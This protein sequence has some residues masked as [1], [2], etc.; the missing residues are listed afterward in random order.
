MKKSNL[1]QTV[2]AVLSITLACSFAIARS[3]A[4]GAVQIDITMTTDQRSQL[5]QPVKVELHNT[6]FRV[7]ENQKSTL[8]TYVTTSSRGQSSIGFIRKNLKIRSIHKDENGKAR[9][10]RVA[11]IEA[12]KV[13][14]SAGSVDPLLTKN[15][16]VYRL[17]EAAGIQTMKTSYAELSIN[18]VSQGLH[19]VSESPDDHIMKSLNAD[20]AFRI[21]YA[22]S[23]EL[24]EAKKS[25]TEADIAQYTAA[26]KSI[27]ADVKN[28]KGAAL[29]ASLQSK[30]NLDRY[31]RL[32]AMNFLVKSGDYMGELYFHGTKNEK[33][34]ICFDVF[35]WDF[36]DSFGTAMHLSSIP[37]YSNNGRSKR[38][39]RQ[40]LYSFE[41][42]LD[43]A[44]SEDPYLMN[45]YFT[46]FGKVVSQLTPE[47][48][49]TIFAEV[50]T[51]LAPYV[52]DPE[53]LNQGLIDPAKAPYTT[54]GILGT[55]HAHRDQ[56]IKAVGDARIQLIEISKEPKSRADKMSG[57]QKMVGNLQQ[58]L[59]Q[60][61]TGRQ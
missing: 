49:N 40:M 7:S 30:L 57:L 48:I 22:E 44:I 19:M 20:I 41:T 21:G 59:I 38:S 11:G 5:L 43:Q 14:L 56:A 52:R 51:K 3:N 60:R 34:E 23:I 53:V 25:L 54:Q 10:L 29:L 32:L 55:L 47:K 61:F 26:L 31:F 13:I 45:A 9:K 16:A 17:Y 8:H 33:G 12:S 4:P 39:E 1:T 2:F 42:K 35:P 15:M 18:G 37:G 24:R 28:L 58:K 50:E 6:E 36:D 46:V 27:S